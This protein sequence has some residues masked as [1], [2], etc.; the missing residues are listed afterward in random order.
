M[1]RSFKIGKVFGIPV[2]IHSTFLLLPL[3]V[4]LNSRGS[5]LGTT[6]F[7]LALLF[8]VFGCVVLHELGHALMARSFGIPTRDITL[9][10]IGGVARLER[11]SEKP[12]QELAIALAGP[13]VNLVIFL[14]L[15][16]VVVVALAL[17][18]IK[19]GVATSTVAYIGF[20]GVVALFALAVAG[21][22]LMLLLFNLLPAF[23]MDGGR[24]FRALLALGMNRLRA[25]EVAAGV[26]LV[27]AGLIATSPFL[28]PALLGNPEAMSFNP[29]LLLLGLFVCF[30]GQMEL[31][32]LRRREAQRQAEAA[33]AVLMPRAEPLAAPLDPEFTG[34]RWDN[35]YHAWVWWYKGRPV[36]DP[37]GSSAE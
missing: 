25:T 13:A 28:L 12:L 35:Q 14:I 4:L 21:S 20:P 24:V 34:F 3:W 37:P 17:D 10:P 29:M 19:I 18:L 26:G 31:M 15:M 36:L 23:P 6:V 1:L 33:L 8:V 11:M 9:Y 30:A 2:Y 32:A 27:V 16:P 7:S 22:N 5:G